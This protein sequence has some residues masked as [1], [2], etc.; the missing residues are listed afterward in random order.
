VNALLEFPGDVVVAL[1]AC[2]RDIEFEDGRLG[3]FGV[4]NFVSAMA[5]SADGSLFR[6]AGHGVP[7]YAL[8]I[9]SDHLCALAAV[10]HYKLLAVACAAGSRNVDVTHAGLRICRRKQFV[11]AAVA[12]DAGGGV[13]VPALKRF[14]VMT[15]IIGGLL[16]GVTCGAT[17]LFGSGFVGGALYVGMAIHA[18]EHAAVDGI[19]EGFRID[20]QANR[21]A[22]DL[23]AERGVA[24]TGEARIGGG[25]GG[26]LFP[27]SPQGGCG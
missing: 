15:A 22:I 5:I 25:L 7:V 24:V 12:V 14:G 10:G 8:L 3:I 13:R 18:G 23:V 16:I 4:K 2:E 11:W 27:G 19:L 6:T 20:M 17:D 1:A 9:R 26:G 21:L